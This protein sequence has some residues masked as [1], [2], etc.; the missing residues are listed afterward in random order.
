[1]MHRI[2]RGARWVCGL[3]GAGFLLQAGACNLTN[4][5]GQLI[6]QQFALPELTTLVTDTLF[7]LLDNA[8]VRLTV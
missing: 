7:F 8:L 2:N 4:E 6:M 3:A 1:M 5:Q